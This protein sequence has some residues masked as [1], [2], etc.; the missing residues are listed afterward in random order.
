MIRLKLKLAVT[1]VLPPTLFA[2]DVLVVFFQWFLRLLPYELLLLP[3]VSVA[4]LL[5]PYFLNSCLDKHPA[6]PGV[7]RGI[8]FVI[9]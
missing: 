6:L 9:A 4:S 3:M 7:S 8:H 5:V 2:C 1:V